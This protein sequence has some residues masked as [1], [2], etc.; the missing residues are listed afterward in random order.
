MDLK[1]KMTAGRLAGLSA[2]TAL[3]LH[4]LVAGQALAADGS[5]TPMRCRSVG[6]AR[7]ADVASVLQP[8]GVHL[9]NPDTPVGLS[10]TPTRNGGPDVNFCAGK[11]PVHGIAVIGRRPM[12]HTCP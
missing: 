5:T 4:P 2:A 6:T 11:D 7:D 9:Q 10:C 3:L 8:L 12:G 1:K